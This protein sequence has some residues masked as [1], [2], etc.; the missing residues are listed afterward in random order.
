MH[1]M[2]GPARLGLAAALFALLLG[3]MVFSAGS[4][5]AQN[6]PATFYGTAEAGDAVTASIGDAECGSATANDD[7]FWQI[8]IAAEADCNPISGST[9][10]FT[11][12]GEAAT[13]TATWSPGG[14]PADVANGIT[15]TVE[16]M[17]E[18]EPEP[19]PVMVPADKGDTGNAGLVTQSG[20][21]ALAVL[22]L[23]VLALAGVAGARTV[24]GRIY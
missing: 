2:K 1:L 24:T 6:P 20:T 7:G 4:A 21:S 10:S 16:V 17:P 14:T 5:L 19:E 9:V 13:E 22:A 18:P 8:V 11:L 23:G 15:L 12:N 3:P